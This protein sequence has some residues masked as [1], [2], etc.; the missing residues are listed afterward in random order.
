M[1]SHKNVDMSQSETE[2]KVVETPETETATDATGAEVVETTVKKAAPKRVRSKTYQAVR[3]QVDKTRTYD[4]F[5]AME[6]VKKLSY[7]SFPGSITAEAVLREK[8]AGTQ[9]SVSFPHSTGQSLRVAIA[10]DEVLADIEAG[11][12]DFD[13]LLANPQYMPKLA[14][15]AKVLGPKGLMPNPKTG[16]LT[17][18]PEQ[19]K[20]ELESGTL[21]IKAERKAPLMHVTFGSTSMESK[22]LVA[23]L[24]ALTDA[25]KGKLVKLTVSATMSPG[26]KVA[27]EKV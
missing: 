24:E 23:N 6:L 7:S 14:K 26:V 18:K 1:G 17:E 20:K 5:S 13:V 21:T 12:I 25:L 4:P 9:V 2:V 19:K 22:D 16:T 3:A 27:V 8:E 11:K 15:L 10:S